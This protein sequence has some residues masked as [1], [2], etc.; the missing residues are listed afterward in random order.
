MQE[1]P[2]RLGSEGEGE[3]EREQESSPDCV[4][5]GS[6]AKALCSRRRHT[7]SAGQ[8][9]LASL[10]GEEEDAVA[11]AAASDTTTTSGGGV[12]TGAARPKGQSKLGGAE[13]AGSLIVSSP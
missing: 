1:N 12:E 13:K 8:E 2:F 10:F 4:S 6:R 5:V 3:A 9:L 7:G 11:T